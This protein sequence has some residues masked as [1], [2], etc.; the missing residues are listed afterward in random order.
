MNIAIL[1]TSNITCVEAATAHYSY[2][3]VHHSLAGRVHLPPTSRIPTSLTTILE[4]TWASIPVATLSECRA[5]YDL[6]VVAKP[7]SLSDAD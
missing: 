4:T 3:C 5:M 1:V 6:N 7:Y 2:S